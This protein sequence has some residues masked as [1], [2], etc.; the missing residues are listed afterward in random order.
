MV[1]VSQKF[2]IED[3]LPSYLEEQTDRQVYWILK[4][5][6][7]LDHT[8]PKYKDKE[9]VVED[10]RAEVCFKTGI[11]GF[12]ITLFFYYF[13]KM[14][15]ERGGKDLN[16]FTQTLDS[17]FG[18]LEDKE[19]NQFQKKCVDIQTVKS[20]YNYFPM[21]GIPMPD[22]H[23]LRERLKGSI[24]NSRAKKYH[25]NDDNINT[26]PS[27]SEQAL[28]HLKEGGDP[29]QFYDEQTKEFLNEND[30]KWL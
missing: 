26:L 8:D 17:H 15:I 23:T 11:S 1:T 24:E 29:L 28:E 14:I 9:I 4:Q 18:C 21:L 3:L 13:N 19:E 2:Q 20:F 10:A 12:H 16:Q 5:I 7:E 30:P 22:E 25:G 27:L 6:P